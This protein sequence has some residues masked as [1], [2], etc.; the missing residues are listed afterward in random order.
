MGDQNKRMRS[1]KFFSNGIEQL[2][3]TPTVLLSE[4]TAAVRVVSFT[5]WGGF[6]EYLYT[7]D[8]ANPAETINSTTKT[9]LEYKAMIVF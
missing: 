9:L 8:K 4:T 3:F 1:R 2:D 5:K 7:M 6:I